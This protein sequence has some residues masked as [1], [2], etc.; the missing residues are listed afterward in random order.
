V[1]IY[2]YIYTSHSSPGCLPVQ[3]LPIPR[4]H[5]MAK[6]VGTVELDKQL[7]RAGSK[8]HIYGHTHINTVAEYEGVRYMQN[9][10]GYGISPGQK[11]CVVHERGMFREYMA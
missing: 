6:G 5:E 7:R 4:M 9:A 1:Y 3:E 10:L 2:I 11:L 8:L